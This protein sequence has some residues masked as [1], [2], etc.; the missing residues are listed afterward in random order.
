MSRD[1]SLLVRDTNLMIGSNSKLK[2]DIKDRLV[3]QQ[4]EAN[5]ELGQLQKAKANLKKKAEPETM[6]ELDYQIR[7]K[8]TFIESITQRLQHMN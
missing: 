5:I 2:S 7:E 3:V 4:S 8:T 1:N 6:A